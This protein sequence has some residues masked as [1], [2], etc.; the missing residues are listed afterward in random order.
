MPN[1][2]MCDYC[3][4][5]FDDKEVYLYHIERCEYIPRKVKRRIKLLK[6]NNDDEYTS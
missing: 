5:K 2:Y 6:K 4:Q 3:R 1:N